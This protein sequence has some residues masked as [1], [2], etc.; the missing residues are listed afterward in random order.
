MAITSSPNSKSEKNY[1]SRLDL[2]FD[3]FISK[4]I[5]R[6]ND[7]G[8]IYYVSS[9]AK[10]HACISRRKSRSASPKNEPVDLVENFEMNRLNLLLGIKPILEKTWFHDEIYSIWKKSGFPRHP[11]PKSTDSLTNNI[12]EDTSKG[13]F[14]F[15]PYDNYF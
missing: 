4:E 10:P 12:L 5:G 2:D 3:S 11:R 13:T 7:C 14:S 6:C 1:Q 8:D 9:S 15:S